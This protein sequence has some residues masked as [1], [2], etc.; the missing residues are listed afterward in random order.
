MVAIL[1]ILKHLLAY[2]I[3]WC[4]ECSPIV[5]NFVSEQMILLWIAV[6]Y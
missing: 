1:N 3:T 6:L 2:G 5:F 4:Y